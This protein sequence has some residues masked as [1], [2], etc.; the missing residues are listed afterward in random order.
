MTQVP[1]ARGTHVILEWVDSASRSGWR[2]GKDAEVGL[3]EVLSVGIVV[4][5]SIDFLTIST[6]L[7]EEG[8]SVH[9]PIA[10][11]WACI[12]RAEEL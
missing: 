12:T 6:C 9:S 2:S 8:G 11:P 1:F 10:I 5:N 3:A 4:N 7:I